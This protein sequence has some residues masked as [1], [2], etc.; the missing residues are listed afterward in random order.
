MGGTNPWR[1]NL[2]SQSKFFPGWRMTWGQHSAYFKTLEAVYA[3]QGI[4]SAAD[5]ESMRKL[6]HER[7]FGSAISAK[8]IDHLK[9]FDAFKAECLAWLQPDS[10]DAQL[11]MEQMPLIRL[12]YRIRELADEPYI[13][14]ILRDRF[15][16]STLDDLSEA[17]LVQ[18]RNTLDARAGVRRK[19]ENQPF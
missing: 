7:A 1:K 14:A 12:R 3:K 15:N 5:K 10:I 19:K 16:N 18:L 8:D 4:T 2:V 9:G 13:E 11:H 17:E 6:I